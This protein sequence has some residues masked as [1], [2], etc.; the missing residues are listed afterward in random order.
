MD[1]VEPGRQQSE[2]DHHFKTD[3]TEIGYINSID[4]NYRTFALESGF[5]TYKLRVTTASDSRLILTVHGKDK[6]TLTINMGKREQVSVNL[7]GSHGDTLYDI[8]IPLSKPAGKAKAVREDLKVSA[9][10]N[11]HL[12]EIRTT[13]N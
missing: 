7:D 6:G 10:G 11:I 12:L 13:K 3:G 8:E 1:F 4:R 2:M 9:N 5:V